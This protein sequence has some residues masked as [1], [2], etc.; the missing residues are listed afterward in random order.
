MLVVS[1]CC[2]VR[3]RSTHFVFHCRD[4]E[5]GWQR[6][7]SRYDHRPQPILK[8]IKHPFINLNLGSR[9][10]SFKHFLQLSLF[11]RSKSNLNTHTWA[12]SIS[13]FII[14]KS[15]PKSMW[16]IQVIFLLINLQ[17]LYVTFGV[18]ISNPFLLEYSKFTS[19]PKCS[20]WVT[21]SGSSLFSVS[22]NTRV[23]NP[24]KIEKIPNT[25]NVTNL[26]AV[27]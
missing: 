25:K 10:N 1:Y 27:G 7:C 12:F 6:L 17:N 18:L 13:N 15:R 5:R 23:R 14:S 24:A 26:G 9:W 19:S 4:P 11:E 3:T 20:A 2:K 16:I 22:G 21:V 8:K